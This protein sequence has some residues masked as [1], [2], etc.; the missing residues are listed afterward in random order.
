[1]IDNSYIKEVESIEFG[2]YSSEEVRKM[3]VAHICNSKLSGN[4]G[5]VYDDRMGTIENGILCETCKMGPKECPGHFGHIE[6]NENIINPLFYKDVR[7]LLCCFCIKCCR[8]LVTKDQILLNKYSKVKLNNLLKTRKIDECSHCNHPQPDFKYSPVDNNISMIYKQKNTNKISIIISVDEIKNIF[9]RTLVEDIVL[10]GMNPDMV[11][12]SNFIMSVF[13]VLPTSSR[14]YVKADGVFCDDDLTNQLVEIIKANNHLSKDEPDMSESKQQKYL[15]SLK[16]RIFTFFNNSSGRSKHSTSG[17]AIKGIKERITGKQGQ[18][19]SNLLGKRCHIIGTTI[20][21]WDGKF[22]KVEDIQVGDILIGDDGNKRTVLNTCSGED[23]M[24]KVIQNKGEPYIVN[25][26]HTL[27]LKFRNLKKIYWRDSLHAWLI[28]WYDKNTNKFIQKRVTVNKKKS[29]EEAYKEIEEFQKT[30]FQEDDVIDIEIEDFL[31]L[32]EKD[33]QLLFGYKLDKPVNW[34]PRDVLIDP[35]ILGM[36][37]GDGGSRGYS[38]TSVDTELIDYYKKWAKD[39][40][41]TI[42]QWDDIHFGIKNTTSD[43]NN[44]FASKL[45]EYNLVDNKHIPEDYI[46]NSVDVRLKFLAGLI[47]TDG[48]V[49]SDNRLIAISQCKEHKCI[50]DGA[51]MI[52]SSLGFQTSIK[53]K[54]TSWTTKGEKKYG[55]AFVLYISGKGIENIP[56][57]L[58]RKRCKPPKLEVVTKSNIKIEPYKR[59]KFYGFEVDGNGR[60]L[61]GDF[62]V[63]HNCN[64]TGRTVIGPDPCLKMGELAIPI[65]MSKNLT[66]P[67]QINN[68][69]IEYMTKLVNNGKA[70][71]VLKNNGKIRINLNYALNGRGTELVYGD[72]VYRNDRVIKY[73]GDKSLN[74]CPG[75]R[76]KRNGNFLTDVKYPYKKKYELEVGDVVERQLQDGDVALLNR[77]PTLHAGSML[78]QKVVIKPYKNLRFNLSI[79]KSFNADFDF[80]N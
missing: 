12:P 9:D 59:S 8:L 29:K 14:P 75:D 77:Q 45:R 39:N 55:D 66:V 47:D 76:I 60:F 68:L 43:I 7:D 26:Q 19:R 62:T 52:A 10:L 32:P 53:T 21:M 70:N 73:T 37:F 38:F 11:R 54:K 51:K 16:F 74:L 27:S 36:W 34:E 30:I 22:K 69:N 15:Q 65:E 49:E 67:V 4:I 31:K 56:T 6:L 33:R 40:N 50:L 72:E 46:Y 1:M 61:L 64:Q 44:G 3:S 13:P 57:L 78:A 23:E 18:I 63:T 5:T 42:T 2:V 71:Y 24:Y 25:T 79:N 41:L 48:S 35:Y 80:S 58:E 17:R 20:L 28:R